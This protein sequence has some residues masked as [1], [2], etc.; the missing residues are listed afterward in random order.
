MKLRNN[1]SK[2]GI[3]TP[4][5]DFAFRP[6]EEY[7]KYSQIPVAKGQ[8]AAIQSEAFFLPLYELYLTYGGI[9]RLVF[10]PKV[11]FDSF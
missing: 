11:G 6:F 1:L 9:F 7:E 8:I 5:L 4:F 10:G 2:I 3:P